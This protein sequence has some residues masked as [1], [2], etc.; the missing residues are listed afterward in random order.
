MITEGAEPYRRRGKVT[1]LLP[2][3]LFV[4]GDQGAAHGGGEADPLAAHVHVHPAGAHL[5]AVVARDGH[6]LF[7]DQPVARPSQRSDCASRLTP[8]DSERSR[9]APATDGSSRSE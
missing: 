8:C 4:V 6:L 7:R 9:I 2:F 3:L 1:L 5:G